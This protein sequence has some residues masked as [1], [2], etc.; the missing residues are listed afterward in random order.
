MDQHRDLLLSLFLSPLPLLLLM[1]LPFLCPWGSWLEWYLDAIF[2][3][4]CSLTFSL[5][6]RPWSY[7]SAPADSFM[8]EKASSFSF[9][10]L[11]QSGCWGLPLLWLCSLLPSYVPMQSSLSIGSGWCYGS[12]PCLPMSSHCV[13]LWVSPWITTSCHHG[14]TMGF[15]ISQGH[16]FEQ[17][18]LEIKSCI[19]I[20]AQGHLLL[21]IPAPLTWGRT[22]ASFTTT[23][24]IYAWYFIMPCWHTLHS[25]CVV[26]SLKA[27]RIGLSACSE[28]PF[29]V[30]C[31]TLSLV[32][33]LWLTCSI[34]A[35][36]NTLCQLQD[37]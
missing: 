5:N 6:C 37:F 11:R 17:A 19:V 18:G 24:G 13:C 7:T 12:P 34:K 15:C 21:S 4:A 33:Y 9:C 14:S 36:K 28:V 10:L 16:N 20:T 23:L 25:K 35:M 32:Y 2:C 26:F 31:L 27:W 8:L 22:H 3:F 1:S 30:A 29:T